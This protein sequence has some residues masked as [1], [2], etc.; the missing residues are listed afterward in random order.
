MGLDPSE[1]REKRCGTQRGGL[2]QGGVW[3]KVLASGG[4]RSRRM[5]NDDAV[6]RLNL[7]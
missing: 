4:K 3:V 6:P 5:N 1:G 7:R 2:V